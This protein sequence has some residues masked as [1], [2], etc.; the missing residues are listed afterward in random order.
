MTSS[1]LFTVL[2]IR[3]S[4]GMITLNSS[5]ATKTSYKRERVDSN[6]CQAGVRLNQRRFDADFVRDDRTQAR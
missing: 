3:P 2:T 6:I 1:T 4:S 5:S